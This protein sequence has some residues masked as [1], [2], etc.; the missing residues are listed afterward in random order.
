MQLRVYFAEQD[1]HELGQIQ[2]EQTV[3]LGNPEYGCELQPIN[4]ALYAQACG[5][6]GLA[7]EDPKDCGVMIEQA[8]ATPGPSSWRRL[9]ILSSHAANRSTS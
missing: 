9:S 1:N 8:L 3:F 2:W 5:G 7:I 4:L 6:T